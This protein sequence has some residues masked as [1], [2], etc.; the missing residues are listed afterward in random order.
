M[1]S[2]LYAAYEEKTKKELCVGVFDSVRELSRAFGMTEKAVYC[3]LYRTRKGRRYSRSE[4]SIR[5]IR[6]P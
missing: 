1:R 6:L 3:N 2:V 5:R 4:I